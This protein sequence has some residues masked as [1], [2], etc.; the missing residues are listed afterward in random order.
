MGGPPWMPAVMAS[1]RPTHVPLEAKRCRHGAVAIP[2][3]AVG[4][5]VAVSPRQQ[6]AHPQQPDVAYHQPLVGLGGRQ[7]VDRGL[8]FG[9][10][11]VGTALQ[12][13]LHQ[14]AGRRNAIPELS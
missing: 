8:G 14:N 5:L 12:Q 1:P 6:C 10:V 13:R 3:V 11:T 9:H 2:I 7:P 4:G